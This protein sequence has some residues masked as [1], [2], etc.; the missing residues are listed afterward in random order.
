MA[1]LLRGALERAKAQARV[2]GPAPAPLA[3]LKDNYRFQVQVQGADGELLRTAAREAS[4][5]LKPPEDVQWQ[6]DVDPLDML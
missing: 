2:L 1:T 4:Q 5:G 6:F 3:K